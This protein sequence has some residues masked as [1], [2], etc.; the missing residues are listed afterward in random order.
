M[1]T[2]IRFADVVENLKELVQLKKSGEMSEEEFV[3]AKGIVLEAGPTGKMDEADPRWKETANASNRPM[4]VDESGTQQRYRRR[5]VKDWL[6]RAMGDIEN[7]GNEEEAD[8]RFKAMMAL[9]Q[10][11]GMAMAP[12]QT[13][14]SLSEENIR[15][16][17]DKYWEEGAYQEWAGPGFEGGSIYGRYFTANADLVKL[18]SFFVTTVEWCMDLANAKFTVFNN[19]CIMD[20][21]WYKAVSKATKKSYPMRAKVKMSFNADTTKFIGQTCYFEN[22]ED[23]TGFLALQKDDDFVGKLK[24]AGIKIGGDEPAG[25]KVSTFTAPEAASS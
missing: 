17:F 9:F 11:N 19:E 21:G 13:S 7:I 8:P 20:L 6:K 18:S 3:A 12:D 14:G 5:S 10:L 22:A 15:A 16:A 4:A 24:A 2:G 23:A 25:L 1:A